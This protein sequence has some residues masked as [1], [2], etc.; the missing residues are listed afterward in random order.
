MLT[1]NNFTAAIPLTDYSAE[2]WEALVRD[3]VSTEATNFDEVEMRMLR[4]AHIGTLYVL[5]SYI[6]QILNGAL[7]YYNVALTIAYNKIVALEAQV[8]NL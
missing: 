1:Y 8:T 6:N 3:G 2:T 7:N 5:K 4:N